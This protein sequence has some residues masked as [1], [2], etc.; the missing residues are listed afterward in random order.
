[1]GARCRTMLG[2]IVLLLPTLGWGHTGGTTGFAV[3]T[4]SGT[5]IRY[6]LTLAVGTL[7]AEL[8][9]RMHIGQPGMAPDYA[10]LLKGVS[11]R[12]ALA[13]GA[14]RCE[15]VPR[16]IA[17]ANDNAASLEIIVDYACPGPMDRLDIRDD[18]SEL[19]GIDYHTLAK[20]VGDG[21]RGQPLAFAPELRTATV[22][23]SADE[24]VA[25]TPAGFFP[26]GIE[27]ILI[28]FDHLLF[29][30]VLVLRGGNLLS[31]LKIVTAFTVAHSITL[32]LAALDV[33]QLPSVMVEAVIALS[34]AWVAAEN[35]FFRRAPSRRWIVS[36]A[37]GLA[38]GFGFS[39]VLRELGL[40]TE[41]LVWA[42]IAFNLGVETG[43]ALAIAAVAP[44]LLLLRRSRHQTRVVQAISAVVLAIG[45]WLAMERI[46]F[47]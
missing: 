20:I 15:A 8:V 16:S 13:T 4:V 39:G 26:L 22:P 32:A 28:G 29:L 7:P 12:I 19:L 11:E 42:L 46:F 9:D 38:H 27:H 36:F 23:L 6:G 45:L 43:Q 33:V 35:L 14:G 34:I 41:G 21:A 3:I 30:L 17:A 37:F 31:L 24:A 2:A 1:M 18:L 10:P 5:T 44:L 47:A 25:R 40:P